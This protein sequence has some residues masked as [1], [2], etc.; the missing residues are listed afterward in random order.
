MENINYDMEEWG[1]L[2]TNNY[3]NNNINPYNNIV[4]IESIIDGKLI[5]LYDK[6]KDERWKYYPLYKNDKN[7]N[8]IFWQI[9]Y[10]DKMIIEY[11]GLI[12]K[13]D[14]NE[15]I[16]NKREEIVELN[17]AI[18]KCRK[19]YINKYKY[20]GYRMMIEPI[21]S[22]MICCNPMLAN[23]YKPKIN[24]MDKYE[25]SNIKIFPVS[26]QPKIDGIRCLMRK[27][28]GK[29]QS[30][31]RLN[32]V[33]PHFDHIKQ[34]IDKFLVYL[35]ED[36]ELDGEI[37]T[38]DLT[39]NELKSIVNTFKKGLH[40]KHNELHYYIFDIIES[41]KK[42]WEDRYKM[43]KKSYKRYIED[44]NESK[45]FT[46]LKSYDA[47]NDSEIMEYHNKFINEGYEGII[48]RKYGYNNK[49]QSYYNT[50][51]SNN[52]LKYKNMT[53]KEVTIIGSKNNK[54]CNEELFRLIVKDENNKI[55]CVNTRGTIIKKKKIIENINK[56]IGKKLTIR[57]TS[58]SEKGIPQH[59]M[60]IVIRD[61]E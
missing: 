21:Q 33:W 51:R 15:E 57:Y 61:Y 23:H 45:T 58:I 32:N 2:L 52:L 17:E 26:V 27:M 41:E 53:E 54:N 3:D 14:N 50:K 56:I 44:G 55:Y 1:N 19:K 40:S 12:F 47:K 18:I 13:T 20:N 22:K 39:V 28:E 25:E 10:N 6:P 5:Y 9:G 11:K 42:D 34:E 4:N 38:M 46:I 37:Y 7:G 29:I 36:V 43:L 48:I 24:K 16:K 8:I 60:G 31:S 30:R 49:K 59:V 35:P